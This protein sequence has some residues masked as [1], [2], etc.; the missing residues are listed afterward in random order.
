MGRTSTSEKSGKVVAGSYTEV[1]TGAPGNV[2]TISKT[3]RSA[4]PRCVR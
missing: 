4:P 3:T 2:L 1:Y